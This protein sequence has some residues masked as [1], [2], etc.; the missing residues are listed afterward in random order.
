MS[1]KRYG[2]DEIG[3]WVDENVRHAHRMHE[4]TAASPRF[5]SAVSPPMSSAC[6]R[7][8]PERKLDQD[9]VDA[10]H[11]AVVQ[12]VERSGVFWI[13]TT[14][15]KGKSCFRACTVNFRTTDA[16]IERLMQLL[17]Q[18]CGSVENQLE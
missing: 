3:R 2:V 8:V 7:Y 10:I 17:E 6:V 13:G 5:E 9:Q 12:R 15:L 14:R 18:E 4:I 16:H 11:H 1:F